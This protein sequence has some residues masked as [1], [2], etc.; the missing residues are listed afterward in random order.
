M[1]FEPQKFFI[2]LVDFFSIIMPGALIAYIGKDWLSCLLIDKCTFELINSE[3]IIIFLFAS[4]FAGHIVFL[5]GS[6]LDYPYDWMRSHTYLGQINRLVNDEKQ[7]LSPQF[8]LKLGCLLFGK[9]ADAPLMQV[10][11]IKARNLNALSAEGSIN[12]YQWC[13]T[14]LSIEHPDGLLAV[15]RYE[16][17]S[18]FFRS[19]V[20]ILAI[21]L[22]V[23]VALQKNMLIVICCVL[24]VLSLWRY[25]DQRF[26]ATRQAYTYVILLEASSDGI[27]KLPAYKREDD[28]VYAGGVVYRKC[29]DDYKFLLIESSDRKEWVLPKGHIEP[30]ENPKE[31]AVREVREETGNWARVVEWIDDIR[32]GSHYS[33]LA[34]Y[35]MMELADETKKWPPESR[36]RGWFQLA[37]A[38]KKT[39][40]EETRILLDKVMKKLD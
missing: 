40:F 14:R 33:P 39:R 31:T 2:G 3:N 28:L 4:Y 13:K 35:Y 5:F 7:E 15:Q 17:N 36:G 6:L 21:L 24:L 37:E 30:G 11:K 20:I 32:L 26:K 8:L 23:S 34:R 19:F 27:Y 12:A 29:H 16:A 25:I 10:L 9:S 1:N 38:K 18:K 22:S